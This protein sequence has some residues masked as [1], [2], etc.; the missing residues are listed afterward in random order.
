MNEKIRHF[1]SFGPFRLDARECLLILD[2]KPV[3][4]APKAFEALFMLVE[5]A[6]HLVD[7]DDLMRRLWP[8]TFVE[9]ANVAK[10]VSLLRKI[11]SEATNGREYIETIPKRGYRFAVEVREIADAEDGSQPQ[12]IPGANLTGKRVSHYRVLEVLGGGGMGVVYKAEDLKLGRRVALKFLPEELGSDAKVLE[13]FEREARAAS[14]LDHPNICAIHEF[15]EH[16]GRPFIA[17]SLLD[18]QTLRDR[19]AVGAAP[20]TSDELLNFAIQIANGLAAAHEKGIVHRDIKPANI[21]ITNRDEAK[22]LDF[23]LAK[24]TRAGDLVNLQYQEARSQETTTAPANDLSLSLTGV[25]MGTLPYMSPEQVRGEKLDARTDLFSFGL[26]IYEMATGKQAFSGDTAAALHEAI[27]NHTPVPARELI[28]DVPLRLEEIINKALEK[29]RS[30]RYQHASEMRADLQRLKQNSESGHSAAASKGAVTVAKRWDRVAALVAAILIAAGAIGYGVHRRISWGARPTLE[31]IQITKL[32]DSGKAEDVAISPDGRYVA[33][34]FRDGKDT[35]LRLRQVGARGEAQVL[36]H[37]ALLF[38]GLAFSPDGN[39]LYFLRTTP[40]NPLSR[41]LYEIPSLGGPQSKVTLNIDSAI[42]F[43]PDGKQFVYESGRPRLDS[44]EIRAANAD[45]SGDRL[46]V[47]LQGAWAG[48]MPGAAWSPDGR[49]IAVPVWMHHKQPGNVLDV[50]STANGG[51]RELY[52]GNQTIGRPRWLPDGNMLVV[53]INDHNERTQLWTM[54]YPAGETRRLTNDLADYDLGIDTTRDGSMLATV[55]WT[56]ISNLWVSSPLDASSGKQLTSGEQQVGDVF[57][58]DDGRVGLVNRSDNGLWIMNADGTHPW[59][60]ADAHGASWFNSCGRFI[61]FESDRSGTS[62]LMR[63]DE[64]GANARGLATG[65]M[66][67]QTCSRDGRFVY[68]AE[69]L[70]PRWKIRRVPIDGGTPEDIVENPGEAIPGRVAISPDGQLLAFPY[71]VASSEPV[72]KIAVIPIAGGP[73]VKRFDVAGDINGPRWSPDGRGLQYQ[74]DK[75]GPTNLW[76]QPLAGGPPRQITKFTSGRIFDFNWT[77]DGKHL[78]LSRGEV[79]SDV[80]LLSNL[81]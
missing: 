5:N 55:Q 35:S 67:G 21:F 24:L 47:N 52:S 54:S 75:N 19:I 64:D 29:D 57:P 33:Y 28:P 63:I 14:A 26:V 31:S 1:Y 62:E 37:E 39:H 4:L 42:S 74:L 3:P 51:V 53:P 65:T 15:G 9:E 2:G 50:I 12:A 44:V 46:L 17:M 8:G 41:V 80:V 16:E 6:G 71:T 78:L 25:A 23:G 43:S 20:F 81:R 68:Y 36:V 45:G 11:L 69:A 27:L 77:A 13:R 70:Q 30:L 32:T 76:E 72:A 58:L 22:I 18:G 79:T 40:K 60:A 34:L 7:K 59:L 38:P 56:T 61:L 66:W 49:S 73:L 10:H 48:D